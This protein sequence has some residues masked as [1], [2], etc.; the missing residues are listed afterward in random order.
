MRKIKSNLTLFAMLLGISAAFAFKTPEPK[1]FASVW[2]RIATSSTRET[3]N[4]WMQGSG[5]GNC[6]SATKICTASFADGY[7]PNQHTLQENTDNAEG[8]VNLGYKAN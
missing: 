4:S 2:R 5:S 6:V 3:S 1:K 7:D 8:T